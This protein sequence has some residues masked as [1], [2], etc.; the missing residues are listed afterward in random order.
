MSQEPAL[1]ALVTFAGPRVVYVGVDVGASYNVDYDWEFLLSQFFAKTMF[2][3][4]PSEWATRLRDYMAWAAERAIAGALHEPMETPDVSGGHFVLATVNQDWTAG[5]RAVLEVGQRGNRYITTEYRTPSG[6]EE[7]YAFVAVLALFQSII[8]TCT[9]WGDL[10]LPAA[11]VKHM[12][13]TY[14]GGP[15]TWDSLEA[16]L[17]VPQAAI[18]PA[19]Q[20]MAAEMVRRDLL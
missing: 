6:Q 8:N 13:A 3:L 18:E 15:S 17:S 16:I 19:M 12:T 2:N 9:A 11:A 7:Y 14:A 10:L 1:S 20:A 4:G 5:V